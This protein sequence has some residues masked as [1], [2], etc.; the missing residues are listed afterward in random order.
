[1]SF[2]SEPSSPRS[3]RI[4]K[5]MC[6]GWRLACE[7]ALAGA[8]ACGGV[9]KGTSSDGGSPDAGGGADGSAGTHDGGG[10]GIACDGAVPS[11]PATYADVP[12]F[13]ECCVA[14]DM[15]CHYYGQ[16]NCGCVNVTTNPLSNQW[17][18]MN[19]SCACSPGNDAGC[20][21]KP[22]TTEADCPSGQHC[23]PGAGGNWCSV[24]CMG[25]GGVPAYASCPVGS[26]C[27]SI[28]P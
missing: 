8:I 16:I 1:V 10:P 7:L 11:C 19:Y 17:E 27:T 25:D 14:G 18:C 28:A 26:T 13:S 24:G 12:Q 2:R 20:I 6:K 5:T 21:N 9:A 22:C 4:V 3:S 23:G 15:S